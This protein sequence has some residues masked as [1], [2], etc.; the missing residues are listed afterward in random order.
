MFEIHTLFINGIDGLSVVFNEFLDTLVLFF[1]YIQA[2]SNRL[3]R[4]IHLLLQ[5]LEFDFVLEV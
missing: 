1:K 5:S 2:I 4:S 3:I